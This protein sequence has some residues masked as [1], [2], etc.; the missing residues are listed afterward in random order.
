M[1]VDIHNTN[2]NIEYYLRISI[3]SFYIPVERA[4]VIIEQLSDTIKYLSFVIENLTTTV[5]SLSVVIAGPT[6]A[7]GHLSVIIEDLSVVF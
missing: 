5:E 6:D 2:Y 4:S 3:Y 1:R 7:F